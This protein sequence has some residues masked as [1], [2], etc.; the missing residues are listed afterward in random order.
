MAAV[1][2]TPPGTSSGPINT[3]SLDDW[4]GQGIEG[5][6]DDNDQVRFSREGL[7]TGARILGDGRVDIHI[8]QHKS[9]LLGPWKQAQRP[10]IHSFGEPGQTDGAGRPFPK[11]ERKS[12]PKDERKSFPLQL[13]LVIQVIGSRGDIQPFIALG[14]EL[15]ADGHRV[16]LATHLAFRELVLDGGLEFFDIGGDPAELMAFM[17]KN[18]GLFPG[19]KAIRTGAIQKRRREMKEIINGCWKS[20]FKRSDDTDLHHVQEDPW[21]KTSDNR[22]RAF[23]ADAIIANPPS[24]AHIHCAQRLGIPLHVMFTMPWSPTQSFPH[25]LAILHPQNLKPTVANFVSYGIVDMVVWQGLGDILN[26]FRK[27]ALALQ[28]LDTSTAPSILHKLHVPHSYLWSPALLPKPPDWP[29]NI[30]VCGFGFLLSE[31]NYTPSK[32]I[33]AFLKAG[34][35]P[36]YVGFGSIVVDDPIKLTK[37]VFEAVQKTGQRALISKGWGNLGVG[38]VDVPDNILIIGNCPHDWLFR[39]VSCVIHHGGAGTTA[40]GLSLGRPT[41]IV[42]FFGDQQFWGDIVARAGAGPAPIPHKHL[43]PQN[44]SEAIEQALKPSTLERAQTIARNMQEESGVRHGVYSFYRHLN[45]QSLRCSIFPDRPA[46]WHLKHTDINL[47]AFAAMVLVKSGKIS[48]DELVLHRPMEYDTFRDPTNPLA[49][50]AQ[51]LLGAIVSFVTGLADAPREIALDIVS[52]ARVM[53]QP[54]EHLDLATCRAAR[55]AILSPDPPPQENNVEDEEVQVEVDEQGDI[56]VSD[57]GTTQEDTGD[58]DNELD[59]N[60]NAK[61][62][63]IDRKRNLQLQKAKTMSS[64]MTPPKPG[65]VNILLETALQ[66]SKMSKKMLK[67]IIWLPADVS[68]S[69]ARGFHNAPKLYHDPTVKDTPQVMG[70]RSGFKVAGK[71][72]RDGLYFGIKGLGTLPRYGLKHEGATGMFKGIGKA[73]GGVFLKPTAG[74]WGLAGYP[75]SGMI[76]CI[77]DALGK[78]QKCMIAVGRISQGLEEM[79][80]STPQD[81]ADVSRRWIAIE[82]D[83]KKSKKRSRS[84]MQDSVHAG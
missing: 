48:P 54:H 24:L 3:M 83:L 36:I 58:V 16:R 53:R 70:I 45:L 69:M 59:A 73:V 11:D 26:T 66:G 77:N 12:F 15:K 33:D 76:R 35:K 57:G 30:D 68:L 10:G 17:V 13:N 14:R 51:V 79:Q 7:N 47:S 29:D 61:I 23:V 64:S 55:A 78:H 4:P 49:A 20:C 81:R 31:V 80:E 60:G 71:E 72:L 56:E 25:P 6:A 74:L 41:I 28:S 63:S 8:D 52:A 5:L 1:V 22:Q 62:S 44:L 42:P 46:A 9:H 75:L 27:N 84:H 32:E 50:S 67:L 43:N 34:P 37:I 21:S 18:P 19:L 39:Q 38:E 2:Q 65:K 82:K 40:A